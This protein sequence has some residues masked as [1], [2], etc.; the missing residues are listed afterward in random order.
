MCS[1]SRLWDLWE[2]QSVVHS[3]VRFHSV[4]DH[5]GAIR[6][7]SMGSRSRCDATRVSLSYRTATK[8]CLALGPSNVNRHG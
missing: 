3:A 1:S 6:F 7:C 2:T 5:A 4:A 8:Q